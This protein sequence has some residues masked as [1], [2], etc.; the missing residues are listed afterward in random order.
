MRTGAGGTSAPTS[1]GWRAS[2]MSNTRTPAFCQVA[3]INLSLTKLPG[4]FSWM[5]CGPK[6]PPLRL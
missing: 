2:P 5:L 6:W 4:R 1:F 3:K